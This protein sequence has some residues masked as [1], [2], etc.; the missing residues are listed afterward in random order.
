MRRSRKDSHTVIFPLKCRMAGLG[1]GD[2]GT[3]GFLD[4]FPV[5]TI[6]RDFRDEDITYGD[7][8]IRP[9]VPDRRNHYVLKGEYIAEDPLTDG[10]P[11]YRKPQLD[12]R[13]IRTTLGGSLSVT[14]RKIIVTGASVRITKGILPSVPR[15]GNDRQETATVIQYLMDDPTPADSN[16]VRVFLRDHCG[17]IREERHIS[18]SGTPLAILVRMFLPDNLPANAI[19]SLP[20]FRPRRENDSL[21][22]YQGRFASHSDKSIRAAIFDQIAGTS[23]LAPVMA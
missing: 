4:H 2:S 7:R 18:N 11:S 12:L 19:R 22:V 9:F 1:E 16:M 3:D 8:V 13:K 10:R 20:K 5:S 21:C 14:V 15:R 6:I 23:G 17:L